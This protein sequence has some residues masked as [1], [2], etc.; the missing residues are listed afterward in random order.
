MR[1]TIAGLAV[2]LAMA[3][4]AHA[5]TDAVRN[6]QLDRQNWENQQIMREQNA[7]QSNQADSQRR[8]ADALERIANGGM[9]NSEMQAAQW[10]AAQKEEAAAEEQR[11]LLATQ[12]PK[13]IASYKAAI[14]M[15]NAS[16]FDLWYEAQ[17][18]EVMAS[19]FGVSRR[20]DYVDSLTKQHIDME[21]DRDFEGRIRDAARRYFV[22]VVL[23]KDAL[24]LGEV[25][26]LADM[27]TSISHQQWPALPKFR[28]P[29]GTPQGAEAHWVL[30]QYDYP[31]VDVIAIWQDAVDVATSQNPNASPLA[32]QKAATVLYT[33]NAL[34]KMVLVATPASAHAPSN[35]S[36]DPPAIIV[37]VAPAPAVPSPGSGSPPRR[38][39]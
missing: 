18:K 27:K 17:S 30:E 6:T 3:A 20:K 4:T 9:T 7:I 29:P 8:S 5:Q 12:G 26:N 11:E 22:M 33:N 31:G 35:P 25:A 39:P 2:T 1:R 34:A 16:R 24:N 13:Y 14:E 10:R 28:P 15:M 38:T 21:A 19:F 32:I 23:P 36:P 37:K